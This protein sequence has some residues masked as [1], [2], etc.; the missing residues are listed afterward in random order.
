MEKMLNKLSR[1]IFINT[2][3]LSILEALDFFHVK[4]KNCFATTD[5]Y[6]Y[7]FF[8]NKESAAFYEG[9]KGDFNY[10]VD[11]EIFESDE[12]EFTMLLL[13]ISKQNILVALPDDES[14]SPFEYIIFKKGRMYKELILEEDAGA[15]YL[16]G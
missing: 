8:E 5:K 7:S 1:S 10:A 15:F 13:N 6:D 2:S 12:L 14:D 4:S 3:S 11:L 16:S 9:V